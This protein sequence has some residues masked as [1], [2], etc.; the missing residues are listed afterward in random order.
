MKPIAV[1]EYATLFE[2][3]KPYY[4]LALG[5]FGLLVPNVGGRICGLVLAAI[6]VKLLVD[7]WKAVYAARTR[8]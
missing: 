8:R 7:R 6:G 5:I 2:T 1:E 3:L 4:C